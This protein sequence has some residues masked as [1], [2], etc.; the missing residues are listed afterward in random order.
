LNNGRKQV[1]VPLLG[2]HTAANALAA[3]AVARRLGLSEDE[4]IDNLSRARGP[5]MRLQLEKSNGVT[6]INDAYN[7]NPASMRAAMETAITLRP[8]VNSGGRLVAVVGDMLEL[9]ESSD[10][11]HREIGSFAASCRFDLLACVGAQGALIADAAEGAGMD[12]SRVLR[13]ATSD[14]AAPQVTHLIRSG[15]VALIKASRGTKLEVVAKAIQA[16]ANS[17]VRKAAS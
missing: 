5:E 13:F 11:F 4:I 7:A 10:R 17:A 8:A 1:F 16:S 12:P 6:V 3:I 9:G 14:A 2:K 15:D